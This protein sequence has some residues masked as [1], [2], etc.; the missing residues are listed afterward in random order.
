MTVAVGNPRVGFVDVAGVAAGVVGQGEVDVAI[1]RINRAPLRAVHRG[2]AHKVGSQTG[3]DQHISLA[4]KAIVFIQTVLTVDQRQPLTG[5]IIIEPGDIQSAFIQQ[6]AIGGRR[7]VVRRSDKLVDVL[8]AGIVA[9]VADDR[10]ALFSR[11]KNHT[12]VAETAHGGALLRVAG[13]VERIDLDHPAEADRLVAIVIRGGCTLD[14]GIEADKLVRTVVSQ[15]PGITAG[16]AG[17]HTV[18]G[19]LA[20][21]ITL[22]GEI[23]GPVLLG[24]HVGAPGR[25]AITAVVQ[26]AAGHGA[27]RAVKRLD[28]I[29]AANRTMDLHRRQ[30]GDTAVQRI[31]L[32]APLV[33]GTLDDA[34]HRYAV[35]VGFLAYLV[36]RALTINQ[37]R[38]G[39]AGERK[40]L[41]C[42]VHQ[43]GFDIL[44]IEHQQAVIGT[45]INRVKV[46]AVVV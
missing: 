20:R 44:V 10:L 7:V 34:D 24:G 45:A 5:A 38:Q 17:L 39:T 32:N 25:I 6:A 41:G 1:G 46:H 40:P 33:V 37:R 27:V 43:A 26:G 3:I 19:M 22:V 28:E 16:R 23:A 12:L 30:R 11:G 13:R 14:A 15:F 42:G 4:G 8:E 2:S 36:S 35:G 21:V 9:R 31:R 29:T 18:T